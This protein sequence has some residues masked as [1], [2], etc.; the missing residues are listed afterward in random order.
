MR[1]R[2]AAGMRGLLARHIETVALG[3]RPACAAIVFIVTRPAHGVFN[4]I[5][6]WALLSRSAKLIIIATLPNRGYFP[7]PLPNP[8]PKL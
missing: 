6:I 1:V 3:S 8:T 2:V 7:G 4:G 5:S